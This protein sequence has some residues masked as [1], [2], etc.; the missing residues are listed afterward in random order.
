MSKQYANTNSYYILYVCL[1]WAD[2]VFDMRIIDSFLCDVPLGPGGAAYINTSKTAQK[3]TQ[4][5]IK[6]GEKQDI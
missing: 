3:I 1:L 6:H 5:S 2:K 4:C